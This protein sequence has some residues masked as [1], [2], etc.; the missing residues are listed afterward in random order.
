MNGYRF[1][2][3]RFQRLKINL[4]VFYKILTPEVRSVTG[5]EEFEAVSLDLGA[6]GIS[7]LSRHYIPAYTA[8]SVSI[9]LFKTDHTGLVSFHDPVDIV[10]E[11]RSSAL[12]E[13]KQYRLGVCFKTIANEERIEIADFVSFSSPPP[14]NS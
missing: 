10:G 2:R 14:P 12:T 1:D 3:R 6:G 7:F 4:S 13:D 11:V 5:E 9:I 8:L